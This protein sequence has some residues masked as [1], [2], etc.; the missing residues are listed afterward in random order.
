MNVRMSILPITRL[1]WWSFGLAVAMPVL[2][3]IGMSFTN[4]LY[5]AVPAGNTILKD[6]ARRPGVAL[7]MLAGM[8]SGISALVIGLITIIGQKERA[9]LVFVSAL[10]GLLLIVFLVGEVI[11]PH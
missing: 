4:L 11:S 3:L 10:A 7:T 8:I 9:L 1:G 5:R 6:I 2:F